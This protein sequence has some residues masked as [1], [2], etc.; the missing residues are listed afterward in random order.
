[1]DWLK[2]AAMAIALFVAASAIE[3]WPIFD[4][5]MVGSFVGLFWF[6]YQTSKE[7][8]RTKERLYKLEALVKGLPE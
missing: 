6:A 2:Y 3:N 7:L 1:M 5:I 4:R 8:D